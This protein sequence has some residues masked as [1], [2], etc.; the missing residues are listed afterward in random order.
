MGNRE[1]GIGNRESGVW[2]MGT[3]ASMPIASMPIASCLLPL[4]YSLFPVP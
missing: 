3:I 4:A 2:E 1:S